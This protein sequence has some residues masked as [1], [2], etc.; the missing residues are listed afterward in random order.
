M[1]LSLEKILSCTRFS[2]ASFPLAGQLS[3]FAWPVDIHSLVF[4]KAVGRPVCYR[5]LP[6]SVIFLSPRSF[7]ST[8]VAPFPPCGE[9][10]FFSET[11]EEVN[12]LDTVFRSSY[13]FLPPPGM[14]PRHEIFLPLPFQEACSKDPFSFSC[15]WEL[16]PSLTHPHGLL[17]R[18]SL[19]LG[20]SLSAAASCAFLFLVSSPAAISISYFSDEK[21]LF[22]G[23]R[24][25]SFP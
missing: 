11:S 20:W 7:P 14:S 15:G 9:L 22:S 25:W 24:F 21:L 19:F 17:R 8:D 23:S 1:L 5:P 10:V 13:F 4:G 12:L 6:N 2:P 16:H 18:C 3:L